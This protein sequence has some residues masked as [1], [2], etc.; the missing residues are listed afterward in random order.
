MH[1]SPGTLTSQVNV[2]K[3]QK[4]E[5]L[6]RL[7]SKRAFRLDPEEGCNNEGMVFCGVYWSILTT[8]SSHICRCGLH[9]CTFLV[10]SEIRCEHIIGFYMKVVVMDCEDMLDREESLCLPAIIEYEYKLMN[11]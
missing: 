3:Q 5:Y 9:F 4:I 7:V 6:K 10:L 11:Q 8:I 2:T 1:V